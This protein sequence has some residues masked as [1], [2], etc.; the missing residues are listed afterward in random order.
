MINKNKLKKITSHFKSK[1][2]ATQL[3]GNYILFLVILLGIFMLAIGA[4]L[5]YIS[6]NNKDSPTVNTTADYIITQDYNDINV[7]NVIKYKGFVEVLDTNLVIIMEEGSKHDVGF[8]YPLQYFHDMITNNLKD[9]YFYS[10]KYGTG[11]DFILITAMPNNIYDTYTWGLQHIELLRE[12]SK[13]KK[14]RITFLKILPFIIFIFLISTMVLYS[15]LTSRIFVKPLKKLLQGVNTLKSGEYSARVEINSLN[16]I[17]KLSDAI[18]LMAE[19]IQ[20][21]ITLKEKSEQ[22]RK[23]I[24]LDI[25]HDLKNPLTSILGYSELLLENNDILP[26]YKNKLLKVINN[27]SK[28]ANDLIQDLFEFSRVESAEYILDIA[29]H[30]IGE[31]L[32]E[33]IAGYVPMMEQNGVHYDVD[34]TEDEVEFPFDRKNLDRALS[35]I[36]L[37]SIKYNSAGITISVKLLIDDGSA[38]IIIEDDGIGIPDELQENIFEPFVRVDATRNSKTGGTGLGLAISK[39]IIEKHGGSIYLMQ[40][41]EKG[42]K[43]IIKLKENG[44]G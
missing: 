33:L 35:N 43:F 22:N 16:E 39:A 12:V 14:T 27:N 7:T 5:L 13:A 11:R 10:S 29:R 23:R 8:K 37:N 4:L 2:M 34:I 30:D 9:D 15:K 36:L 44:N 19:K 24:I 21:E 38:L 6:I 25:S 28:R 18:N 26:E 17:G 41:I 42:C 40:N 20:Q 1:K 32:R 31:F 3:F